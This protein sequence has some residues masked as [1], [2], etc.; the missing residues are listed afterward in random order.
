MSLAAA[1]ASGPSRTAAEKAYRT[2]G[3]PHAPW[4]FWRFTDLVAPVGRR[5]EGSKAAALSEA[6]AGK[7][8]TIPLLD[9]ILAWPTERPRRCGE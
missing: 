9:A 2:S 4:S 5:A 1:I 3:A 8:A 6:T 7:A